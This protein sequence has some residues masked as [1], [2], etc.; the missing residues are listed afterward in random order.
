M[1]VSVV[2]P[3]YNVEKYLRE[4]LD[5]ICAQSFRDF[6]V[7]CIND[8]SSDNSAKIADEYAEK[9]SRF[10]VI[11][12]ENMGYGISVNK[13]I[14][15]AKG[16]YLSI[17]EPDDYIEPNM[18][19]ELVNVAEEHCVD[20]VKTDC[21]FFID[22]E[23]RQFE[24]CKVLPPKRQTLYHKCMSC[25]D[26]MNVF[27]G[28]VYTWAGLYKIDFLCEKG[29]KHNETPGASYQDNGFWFQTTMHARRLYF[30]DGAY[31]NYRRDNPNSS[32]LSNAKVFCISD[33]F[34]FIEKKIEDCSLPYRNELFQRCFV[35]RVK[36]YMNQARR[37]S[38]SSFLTLGDRMKAD[39]VRA[40][41]NNWINS[42]LF[43]K[44]END[45]VQ[46]LLDDDAPKKP[47]W[48]Y[49][50]SDDSPLE[51]NMNI[52]V[53]GAGK[54]AELLYARMQCLGIWEFVK[55]VSVSSPEDNPIEFHGKRV[56]SF[57]DLKGDNNGFIIA[58]GKNNSPEVVKMV[59]DKGFEY[60]M[61]DDLMER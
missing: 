9:D 36:N 23:S 27:D 3:I 58:M 17:V 59:V 43:E 16:K 14:S 53:Y 22:G 47:G 1:L 20:V 19:E 25:R 56:F 21:R 28:Y 52:Y 49:L 42:E 48:Y 11:S 26:D 54:I 2:V 38:N 40:Y 44:N 6:E 7:I 39:V 37:L 10:T 55:G 18:L 12:Q 31:Y 13:G 24:I 46:K 45:Y 57:S 33:E 51:D 61:A 32:S 29:I 4:C 15:V 41:K 34:D 8:G 50:F 35:W 60:I 5:S 30:H